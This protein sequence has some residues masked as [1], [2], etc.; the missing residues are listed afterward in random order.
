MVITVTS[1]ESRVS[2]PQRY[3]ALRFVVIFV[4]ALSLVDLLSMMVVVALHASS[5]AAVA[6]GVLSPM[7]YIL[8]GASSAAVVLSLVYALLSYPAHRMTIFVLVLIVLALL[9]A[10]LYTINAPDT[11]NCYDS[12][13]NVSGCVMDEVY[14]VPAA[15]AMLSG[16]KCAPYADNCN[17][18]HPFLSKAFIAAGI[19]AFGNDTFGWR[20]FNVVLGTFSIPLI[21]GIC[22][23]ITRNARLSLFASFLLA[24]ETLF[25]VHSS[26]AVIDV[27]EIF[28]GLLGFFFYFSKLRWWKFGPMALTAIA[29]GLAALSKE[30]A[31][32]LLLALAAYHLLFGEGNWAQRYLRSL[33]LAAGVF[34]VFAVGLQVYDSLLGSGSA[35]TFWGQIEFILKYGASLTTTPTSQGWTDTVLHTPIT[36]LNWIT[37]YSPVGYLI[38][39]VRVTSGL[40]SFTY[41]SVG[42]YGITDQFEVWLVYLWGAYTVYIWRKTK[43]AVFASESEARDFTLARLALVWFLVVFLAYVGLYF[44]GRITYPYYFIS[45][46]PALAMGGVYFLTRSWFPRSIAYIVLGGVVLWFFLFYP[47]KSFL[48][49]QLRVWIGH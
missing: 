10:H 13:K 20:I 32:M 6:T 1:G 28:F 8:A 11:T 24:F 15:Q 5:P 7:A 49:V 21:F 35:T 4:A 22:W 33:T 31:I 14:Y 26:I 40:T 9:G 37:Y 41:V 3:L 44:Y 36:P 23:S 43:G 38:T 16:E 47:D 39:N 17:L 2:A 34:V 29:F 27:G 12:G 18:E 48:P 45:A 25:F 42:Y 46:V 30:T 19:A